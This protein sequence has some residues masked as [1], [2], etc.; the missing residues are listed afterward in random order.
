MHLTGVDLK[1]INYVS[2]LN[3]SLIPKSFKKA[4]I[5]SRICGQGDLFFAI[6][7]E[8][9][10]GHDFIREVFEKGVRCA[11]VNKS[12]YN[13]LNE[14]KKRSFNKYSFVLVNDTLKS[15]GMLAN[16]HRRK[17]LI[18]IIA[19]GGSNGKTSAK[20][21]IAHVLSQ[22]YNV[23]KTEGNYNNAYGVPLTLF[24]LKREHEIAVIEVGTNHFGEV[25]YLSEIVM[26]QIGLITNIGKEHLEFLKD[27]KGA[28]KAECELVDYLNDNF[29]MFFLNADDKI[30]AR[31]M[32]KYKINTFSY[33]KNRKADL[34]GR[35]IR[36]NKLNPVTEVKYRMDKFKTVLKGIGSQ[37]FNA[38]LSAAAVGFYFE[39]PA[40][41]IKKGISEYEIESG[42]R[43]QLKNLDGIWLIDDSYNSN[44]DS[45]KAALENMKA[46]KIKG[47]K[48]LVLADMLELGRTAKKEHL[49]IGRLIKRM[50]FENLYT[51]GKESFNTFIGAKGIKNNF[52]FENKQV[53]AEMLRINIKKD[54]LILIKGSRWMKMEE[55][56][57]KLAK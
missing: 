21:Y 50:N 56:I 36:F 20:D 47:K 23:L 38:A 11:V 45:V 28:A 10:D 26:P 22:R 57:E 18:P 6:K 37:S 43:N 29:G 41:L 34:K 1:K 51:Y 32:R 44:P 24:R 42:K 7:G 9:F 8:R 25:K 31:Q 55:I 19:I 49:D 52:Y 27:L 3:E 35:L 4:T 39:V 5:D 15:L 12:W 30:L 48:H 13:S 14:N 54:D 16:V 33:G 46:Y 2:V 17:F 40:N 53:L